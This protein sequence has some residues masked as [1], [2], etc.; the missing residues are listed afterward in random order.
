MIG[1][2]LA[3]MIALPAGS[4]WMGSDDHYADEAPVRRREVGAFRI[5]ARP[6]TNRDFARFVKATGYVTAAER[7]L[8]PADYPTVDPKRLKPG[9]LVFVPPTTKTAS[10]WSDWWRYTP[11]AHWLKPDGKTS[12]YRGRL[13]H[14]VVCVAYEDAQTFAAW[15]GKVLP[16][17]VQWEYAAR[18][19]LERK[20][21]AWGDDFSPDGQLMA[22]TWTGAFPYEN[23]ALHGF[24]GPSPA[25][26]FPPNG[27]GLDDMIGNVW[28]WTSDWYVAAPG[29]EIAGCC[30][31]A[32][33]EHSYDPD[34]PDIRIP[35]RVVKGGSWLCHASY[36][37]R[38]RPA[39]RQPQMVDTATGHI[40]FRCVA[41]ARIGAIWP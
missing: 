30:G 19:G 21:Y 14:P 12:V 17:E 39:A 6:V 27:Y 35:R 3:P 20:P 41:Q 37:A 15:A 28:E 4:F 2:D 29:D 7:S 11:R 32:G 18:G 26:A 33:P 40:G 24:E 23:L 34:L 22:N 5:D 8:D 16:T 38:Y 31:L 25:G 10:H 1:E 36:C 9:A 13:D